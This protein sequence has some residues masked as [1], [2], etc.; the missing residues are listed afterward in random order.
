VFDRV[1]SLI[2][3]AVGALVKGLGTLIDKIPGLGDFGLKKAGQALIDTGKG[4]ASAADE[5]ARKRKELQELSFDDALNGATNAANRFSEALINAA[6]GFKINSYRFGAT[7]TGGTAA[8][9]GGAASV[10]YAGAVFHLPI[11]GGGASSD[12]AYANWK[13]NVRRE[14]LSNPALR[15][16]AAQLG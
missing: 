4:L 16:F 6:Q 3:R 14:A 5:I 1:A 8:A 10:S 9:G 15:P 12:E 2:L 11:V 7:S 13:A